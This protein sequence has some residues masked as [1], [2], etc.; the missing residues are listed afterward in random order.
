MFIPGLVHTVELWEYFYD[1]GFL[2]IALMLFGAV[3]TDLIRSG[4]YRPSELPFWAGAVGTLGV[5]ATTPQG[6]LAFAFIVILTSKGNPLAA[7]FLACA[8]IAFW[9][10]AFVSIF[11]SHGARF[12]PGRPGLGPG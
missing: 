7:T 5:L 3:V 2:Y 6:G 10:L 4:A 1:L 9:L 8:G 12:G 11:C